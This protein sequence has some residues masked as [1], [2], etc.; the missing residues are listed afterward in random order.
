MSHPSLGDHLI[1]T[2]RLLHMVRHHAPRAHPDVDPMSVP[3]L[4]RVAHQPSRLSVLAQAFHADLS[5]V[6]RQVSQLVELGML[7]KEPDP[8]DG[9][10]SVL[11]ITDDG[12]EL[13]NRMRHRRD[14]WIDQVLSDWSEA[15]RATFANL[16]GRFADSV[17]HADLSLLK[18]NS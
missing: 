1:R 13:C 10:A 15:D 7:R 6:S 14:R 16:L 12:L 18:D 4:F 2:M 9:R 17:E 3:L 8:E 5:T 11:V